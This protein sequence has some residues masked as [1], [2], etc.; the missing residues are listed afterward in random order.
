LEG[1][2]KTREKLKAIDDKLQELLSG[3]HAD[4]SP[5]V[6]YVPFV[7]DRI[8][9]S[10]KRKGG[11]HENGREFVTLDGQSLLVGPDGSK[12]HVTAENI[13]RTLPPGSRVRAVAE[14]TYLWISS[15]TQQACPVWTFV[16]GRVTSSDPMSGY[17]I[18]A[19]DEDEDD[20]SNLADVQ[21]DV[22]ATEG[23]TERNEEAS[24]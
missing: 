8:A 15:V 3:S 7:S 16:Q 14:F 4:F 2:E 22:E 21:A 24:I 13:K 9:L 20:D 6:R 1:C 23:E 5:D 12:I 11:S 17:D 18:L 19:D 10:L